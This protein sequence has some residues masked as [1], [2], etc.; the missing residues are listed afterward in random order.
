MATQAAR[1]STARCHW[2][3]PTAAHRLPVASQRSARS[4]GIAAW[5]SGCGALA[6][7]ARVRIVPDY[8]HAADSLFGSQR[9][10]PRRHA[11]IP[12]PQT[13]ST[14]LSQAAASAVQ[15]GEPWESQPEAGIRFT[16]H[17]T[18]PVPCQ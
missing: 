13:I 2:P 16:S 18:A 7:C 4:D 1:F 14:L 6:V 15:L 5:M 10:E 11:D 3:K 8:D 17:H 12:L 9:R